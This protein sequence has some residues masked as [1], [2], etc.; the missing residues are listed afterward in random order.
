MLITQNNNITAKINYIVNTMH[1]LNAS[2]TTE[3]YY[4]N[5]Y[6]LLVASILSAQSTDKR[7]NIIT[8]QLFQ[9]I[10][11]PQEMLEFGLVNLLQVIK[12]IG[13]Y[14]N[15]GA[16]IIKMSQMLVEFFHGEVPTTRTHLESLPGVGKKTA[17]I[18]LNVIFGHNVIPVDT[19]VFRV[20]KRLGIVEGKTPDKVADELEQIVPE[21]EKKFF[22]H[23][24][25][26]HGRYTCTAKK[27]LC[28]QCP[29]KTTCNYFAEQK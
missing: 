7:V 1:Q 14:N 8:Q 10:H 18:I 5:A 25:V 9:S 17:G 6:T 12:T 28:E 20:S 21:Q 4:I 22:H 3:L 24:L 27:P 29:I 13:L 26:L 11:T 16:N 15:K 23:W 2:P 19:H